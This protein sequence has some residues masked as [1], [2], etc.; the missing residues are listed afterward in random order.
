MTRTPPALKHRSPVATLFLPIA[1]LLVIAVT[2]GPAAAEGPTTLYLP[3]V[4]VPPPAQF[5]YAWHTFYDTVVPGGTQSI[6][7][8]AAGNIYVTGCSGGG[9]LGPNGE[10]PV[11]PYLGSGTPGAVLALDPTGAYKWHTFIGR[12][13]YGSR[14]ALGDDGLIFLTMKTW[15]ETWLGPQG[16]QPLYT[17]PPNHERGASRPWIPK[18]TIVGTHSTLIR[19]P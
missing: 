16:Q 10:Q 5:Q 17:M 19:R 8:D 12:C 14:I 2:I 3:L 7:T 18:G 1:I 4:L 6:A 9:W 13:D 11:E 15:L